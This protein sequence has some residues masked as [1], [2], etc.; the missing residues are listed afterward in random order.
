MKKLLSILLSAVLLTAALS[1]TV[2]ADTGVGIEPGQTMPDFTVSLTDG[3]TVTLSELLEEKDL[4][5]L[6][7]FASWCGPCERE[8]PE[9]DAV[10][11]EN[12]R[13]EIVAVSCEPAD[14][15]EIIADYKESHGLSFPMGLKGDRGDPGPMGPQGE[16]GARGPQGPAGPQGLQGPAGPAGECDCPLTQ[17]QYEGLLVSMSNVVYQIAYG[18]YGASYAKNCRD[19]FLANPYNWN[20]IILR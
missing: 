19:L 4:V 8:F 2:C 20:F 10:R 5:V 12:P 14:T 13:M 17:E 6:N 1:V 16:T 18:M 11:L 7:L 15:M 3:T 9:M